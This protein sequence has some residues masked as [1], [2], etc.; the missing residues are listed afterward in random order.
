MLRDIARRNAV[1]TI[2]RDSPSVSRQSARHSKVQRR[3][4]QPIAEPSRKRLRHL[5]QKIRSTIKNGRQTRQRRLGIPPRYPWPILVVLDRWLTS[6]SSPPCRKRCRLFEFGGCDFLKFFDCQI[7][8]LRCRL[9][10]VALRTF[11]RGRE[12]TLSV[13]NRPRPKAG[14]ARI[15]PH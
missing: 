6:P 14:D 3:G 12:Y 4:R 9:H 7:G 1:V 5:A 10:N 11:A 15:L 2:R 13:A 8:G